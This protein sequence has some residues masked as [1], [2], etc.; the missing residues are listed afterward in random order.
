MQNLAIRGR[1]A[2][3]WADNL[4]I[5]AFK[6]QKIWSAGRRRWRDT[7]ASSNERLQACKDMFMYWAKIDFVPQLIHFPG[8]NS[9]ADPATGSSGQGSESEASSEHDESE[10]ESSHGALSQET[11]RLPGVRVS[12]ID[13]ALALDECMWQFFMC[14]PDSQPNPFED[15]QLDTADSD[16][17]CIVK[18]GCFGRVWQANIFTKGLLF[19]FMEHRLQFLHIAGGGLFLT[20]YGAR[21]MNASQPTLT[22]TSA[23]NAVTVTARSGT[24]LATRFV[25]NTMHTMVCVWLAGLLKCLEKYRASSTNDQPTAGSRP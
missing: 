17:V 25:P 8:P 10:S 20:S 24:R 13:D 7:K 6:I 5:A 1:S 16:G 15:S 14:G 3:E 19:S 23:I 11:L 4:E 18:A 21:L 2:D 9:R 12:S 22:M